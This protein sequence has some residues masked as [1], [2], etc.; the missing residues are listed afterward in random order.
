MDNPID[1]IV[2]YFK[3]LTQEDLIV[4]LVIL[5]PAIIT[6]ILMLIGETGMRET[7]LRIENR[8]T[9]TWKEIMTPEQ[10]RQ[11]GLDRFDE[12]EY[13]RKTTAK[14][15]SGFNPEAG[16]KSRTDFD[17]EDFYDIVDYHDGLDGEYSDID[18]HDIEDYYG[19]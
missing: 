16:S 12:M 13:N 17:K 18:Y 2:A 14:K 11:T 1:K 8:P 19:D 5:S 10:R 6:A 15:K 3:N 9:V 4:F 7:Q